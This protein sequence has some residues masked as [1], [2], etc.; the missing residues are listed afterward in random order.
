[1]DTREKDRKRAVA[2]AVA[3][4]EQKR[5]VTTYRSSNLDIT[6][7]WQER[8]KE[9]EGRQLSDVTRVRLKLFNTT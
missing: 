9:E 4:A 3:E 1:M 5:W 8:Q 2:E 7:Q 6:D